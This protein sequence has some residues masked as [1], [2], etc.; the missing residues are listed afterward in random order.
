MQSNVV[1]FTTYRLKH[2]NS[3]SHSDDLSKPSV[4]RCK[5]QKREKAL[6]S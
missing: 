6:I 4:V 2:V 3:R 1:C 5:N